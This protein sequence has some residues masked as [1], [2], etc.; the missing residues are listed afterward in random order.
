MALFSQDFL[1]NGK[2]RAGQQSDLEEG[3]SHVNSVTYEITDISVTGNKASVTAS[4]TV[5]FDNEPPISWTEPDSG[6]EGLGMGWL[7]QE[8]GQWLVYGNQV[9]G[10]VDVSSIRDPDGTYAF[11]VMA[12][13]L[14]LTSATVSGPGIEPTALNWDSRWSDFNGPITPTPAPQVGDVYSFDLYYSDGRH[15]TLT[16][17]ITSFVPVGPTLTATIQPDNTVLLSWDDVTAQVPG[18]SY[19]DVAIQGWDGNGYEWSSQD[20]GLSTTSLTSEELQPGVTYGCG[21]FLYN[22]YGDGAEYWLAIT[23]PGGG[24]PPPPFS[25]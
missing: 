9:H 2:D 10:K 3:I 14:G 17:T 24:P 7:I 1:H 16:D 12:R 15:E 21:L 6:D 18:A 13:G 22:T 5:T 20:L 11:R 19:Y 23:I 25:K 4:I 8:N